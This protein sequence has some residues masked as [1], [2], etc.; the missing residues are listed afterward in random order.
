[1]TEFEE[2]T[3]RP[4]I[5]TNVIKF[6][7]R[8]VDDT[9][10]LVKPEHINKVHQAFNR[11][12]TN[13]QF[14]VDKFE[15]EVPHFLDLEIAPDGLSIYRK[16]TNTGLYTSYHSYA[17]WSY[18]KAWILSL[19]NRAK[20]ICTPNKLNKELNNIK[21]FASWNGFPNYV[22]N[23]LIRFSSTNRPEQ[24]KADD[25]RA[26]TV[27]WIR[28]PYAGQ[29]G[30]NIVKCLSRKLR[31]CLKKDSRVVFKTVYS[32]FKV[33]YF[34]NMKD[35]TPTDFRS[36]VVYK[37]TCPGC[38]ASYVGKTER[39]LFQRCVEHGTTSESAIRSHLGN[40]KE[41]QYLLNIFTMQMQEFDTR[42]I[43]INL[44]KENTRIIDSH[45]NWSILLIKEALHIKRLKPLLN[46]GL[47][48]SRELRLF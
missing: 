20:R 29:D 9:L 27:I 38:Q 17:P 34:T 26:E 37:F 44:V 24:D 2:T 18:R 41:I 14:T 30:E 3:L 4:L 43:L 25:N 42:S 5:E 36:N 19:I 22:T 21:Q 45:D 1:M 31:S 8:Y 28:L 32:T 16:E 35:K 46:N 15:H 23:K 7:G 10:L 47:K 11:F 39:N 12:D 40:C 33:S 48:A 13:I 6:Y